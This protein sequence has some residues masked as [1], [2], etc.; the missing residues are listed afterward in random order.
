MAQITSPE[1]LDKWLEDKPAQWGK[2]IAV[3]NAQR[4][5][6]LAF[7]PLV[8]D[9]WIVDTAFLLFRALFIAQSA[10]DFPPYDPAVQHP[11]GADVMQ[12]GNLAGG[13]AADADNAD[14]LNKA[15]NYYGA[16]NAAH[17]ATIATEA[18]MAAS[19]GAS[20]H[21][22]FCATSGIQPIIGYFGRDLA[23]EIMTDDI[24][25]LSAEADDFRIKNLSQPL[26]PQGH[27]P[28]W[29][30]KTWEQA[31][32][33][34]LAIDPSY[35][36]WIE[37]YERRILGEAFVFDQHLEVDNQVIEKIDQ[38]K[39]AFWE[40]DAIVVNTTLQSWIDAARE[41][42]APKEIPPQEADALA[43]GVNAAGK[44]DRLPATDQ[45]HLRDAPDQQRIYRDVREAA[46]ELQGE[47]QRLGARLEK[48]LDRFLASLP[49]NF[50]DAEC[51]S[52]WR[53][54]NTLRRIHL[55]HRAV[56]GGKDYDDKRL[57][58][59][60]A[61]MLGDVL[62]RYNL[63][64]FGDDGLRA[65]DEAAI[66]PQERAKAEEEAEKAAPLID[67]LLNAPEIMTEIVRDDI[68]ADQADQALP[69]GDPYE[70]QALVQSN[71][72]MRNRI[73][74]LLGWT[75]RQVKQ[76]GKSIREGAERAVGALIVSDFAGVTHVHDPIVTFATTHFAE[77]KAYAQTAYANTSLQ[78]LWDALSRLFV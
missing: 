42:V 22:I 9:K 39:Y 59:A 62:D 71:K 3:R 32:P 36:V 30:D 50:G 43:Y 47:G 67:A 40:Q 28:G 19:A 8:D 37:W 16:A 78:W 21:A 15:L 60:M 72:S 52:I 73:A 34:L 65:K 76:S 23:W 68:L 64:A 46:L 35:A 4:V 11:A 66:P 61:E 24:N 18:A 75:A 33:R 70:G 2:F 27:R 55:A 45:Q 12:A 25:F 49:E 57:D 69:A 31:K 74:A 77:L 1:E 44:L 48:A 14:S 10:T 41:R 5:L 54:G 7:A 38:G 58:A 51:Y 26:W 6:P 20:S 53:D 17:A 13:F 56:A 29:F 63:F